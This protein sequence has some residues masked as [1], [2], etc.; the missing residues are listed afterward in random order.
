MFLQP[1]A[2]QG[3]LILGSAEMAERAAMSICGSIPEDESGVPPWT[4]GDD[5]NP[6]TDSPHFRLLK[7]TMKPKQSDNQPPKTGLVK[8]YFRDGQLCSVGRYL[9]GKKT[10][11]WKYYL[12]NGNLKATGKYSKGELTGLWK[13]YRENG[14]P[15]QEGK[16]KNGKQ[17]GLWKRYHPNGELYDVGKYLDGKKT[18]LWKYYDAKGKLSRTKTY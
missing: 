17:E 14:N 13:W 10:G 11:V 4:T 7:E 5:L 18:G 6:T 2:R 1:E 9:D 15:L 8:E 3:C 16:F 12:R